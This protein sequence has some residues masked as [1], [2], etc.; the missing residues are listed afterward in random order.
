MSNPKDF[1]N[2][3]DGFSK[4]TIDSSIGLS[5]VLFVLLVVSLLF[6]LLLFEMLV[7]FILL[8]EFVSVMLARALHFSKIFSPFT[9]KCSLTTS[10]KSEGGWRAVKM[11]DWMVTRYTVS[12]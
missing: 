2:P 12:L 3:T 11:V 5:V 1:L 10:S 8:V 9:R 6:E 7:E 4:N